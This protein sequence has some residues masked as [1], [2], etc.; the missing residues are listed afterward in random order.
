MAFVRYACCVIRRYRRCRIVHRCSKFIAELE[1]VSNNRRSDITEN[2]VIDQSLQSNVPSGSSNDQRDL[3][4]NH[5]KPRHERL[6]TIIQQCMDGT[7]TARQLADALCVSPRTI[8]GDVRWLKQCFPTWFIGNVSSDHSKHFKWTGPPL[9]LLPKPIE[10]L[11]DVDLAA[12]VLARGLLRN[13]QGRSI[14]DKD[15]AYPGLFAHAL[16]EL[17][18]RCGLEECADEISPEAIQ[19]SRFATRDEDPRSLEAVMAAI[20]CNESIEFAYVNRHGEAHPVHAHPVRLV[21]IKGEF[22]CFAWAGRRKPDDAGK[23]SLRQYR[24]S[25]M[26][27]VRRTPESPKGCPAIVPQRLVDKEL[28]CAFETTGSSDPKDRVH[29]QLAVS[30]VA[31]PHLEERTF[32]ANQKWINKPRGLPGGW[33]RLR[34]TTSGLEACR[35]WVLGLGSTVRPERPKAL[36]RWIQQEARRMLDAMERSG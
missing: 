2:I 3:W 15:T 1:K 9:H 34:F 30:P 4:S 16:H 19:V 13:T 32:G 5:M 14:E 33:R 17:L 11:T 25:R 29:V 26:S 10:W 12:I 36:A 24:I 23:G 22:H 28:A 6:I 8:A 20:A 35:Y 31:Y 7:H 21:L 18:H 27:E